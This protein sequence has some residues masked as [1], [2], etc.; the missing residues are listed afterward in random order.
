MAAI[1]TIFTDCG[2]ELVEKLKFIP[3]MVSAKTGADKRNWLDKNGNFG[4]VVIRLTEEQNSV[5]TCCC[6]AIHKSYGGD[7]ED[8]M[9]YIQDNGFNV[10][11]E[12]IISYLFD[13]DDPLLEDEKLELFKDFKIEP[14]VLTLKEPEPIIHEKSYKFTT[15][16]VAEKD[17]MFYQVCK[18]FTDLPFTCVV[19]NYSDIGH[20]KFFSSLFTTASWGI[21]S[22][23]MDFLEQAW[24]HLGMP[25]D[26]YDIEEIVKEQIKKC[27]QG[28]VE[29][30]VYRRTIDQVLETFEKRGFIGPRKVGPPS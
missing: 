17:T 21:C 11:I 22:E 14:Q 8:I 27:E 6:W 12:A 28:E 4:R 3:F 10:D 19:F 30:R 20:R 26:G 29:P 7:E 9:G 15:R 18:P 1:F 24:I 13:L 25:P 5:F 23:D 2:Q 16:Y